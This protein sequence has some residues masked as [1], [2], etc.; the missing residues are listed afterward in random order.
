M[1]N[2]QE[3]NITV[4]HL[5]RGEC[6]SAL[7]CMSWQPNTSWTEAQMAC[8]LRPGV[9]MKYGTSLYEGRLLYIVFEGQSPPANT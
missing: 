1:K 9:E 3:K 8:D 7:A 6:F 2:W 4:S 5:L